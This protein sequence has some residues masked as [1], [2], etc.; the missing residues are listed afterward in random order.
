[1]KSFFILIS[2]FFLL[3][4]SLSSQTAPDF[5]E[6][7]YDVTMRID[8]ESGVDEPDK[9]IFRN[10]VVS[11]AYNALDLDRYLLIDDTRTLNDIASS[12]PHD[13]KRIA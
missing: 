10:T 4:S 7:F 13:V 3:H 2:S 6:F 8:Y 5:D 12:V 1:M 11:A 9:G